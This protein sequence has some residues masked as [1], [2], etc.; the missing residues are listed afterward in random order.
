MTHVASRQ[1][2]VTELGAIPVIADA[3]DP[4]QVAQVVG[5]ILPDVIVHQLTSI[6]PSLNFRHLD[7]DFETTNRL[8]IEGTDNLLSA[9]RTVGSTRFVAQSNGAFLYARTGGPVKTEEDPVDT[10]PL[11]VLRPLAAA[12][13]HLEEAVLNATWTQGIVLRYG[14]FY[15]P[16]TSMASDAAQ[17]QLIRRRR[18]PVVGKGGGIWSFIHVADAADATVAAIERANRGIYNIVD[19]D[20]AL[21]ADWLPALAHELGAKQPLRVP[22]FVGRIFAGELGVEMMT[23]LRGASNAKA[24]RELG[25]RPAHQSWRRGFEAA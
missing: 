15:G 14:A 22:R 3:L 25:W 16:H 11:R 17:S 1:A 10:S 13:V 18:L 24:K 6:P 8:R 20:P 21:V 9:G 23:E 19:D 4:D 2:L 12:I 7:R 5:D